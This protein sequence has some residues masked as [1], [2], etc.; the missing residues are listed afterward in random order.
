M[1][2]ASH[3]SAS[4]SSYSLIRGSVRHQNSLNN[5]IGD[6]D[7]FEVVTADTDLTL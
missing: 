1:V 7:V 4:L 2:S 3:S 5:E 6:W